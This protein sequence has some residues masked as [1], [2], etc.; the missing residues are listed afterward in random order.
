MAKIIIMD[1]AAG[2]PKATID[3]IDLETTTLNDLTAQLI[4]A[5][6]LGRPNGRDTWRAIDNESNQVITDGGKS[7][8]DLGFKDGDTITFVTKAGGACA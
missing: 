1:A 5:G 7:L 8:A 6:T 3:D 4:E 2:A